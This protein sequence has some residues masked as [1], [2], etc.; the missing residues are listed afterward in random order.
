MI[1]HNDPSFPNQGIDSDDDDIKDYESTVDFYHSRKI[2]I[3]CKQNNA[4]EVRTGK[5]SLI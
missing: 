5:T 3:T 1:E 4:I 2:I